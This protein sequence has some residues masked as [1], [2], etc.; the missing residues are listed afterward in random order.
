ML[1][2]LLADFRPT[3]ECPT[4]KDFYISRFSWISVTVIVICLF[5]TVFSAI[6]LGL[7]WKGPRYGRSITSQGSFKPSDAILLT[8]VMAK[9]IELSFVTSFVAFL[10]QV[11]SRRA[12]MREQGRGVTLSELSMWRW[13]VQPGT[14]ITHWETAKYAGISFLGI[15]SL[16]S[17]LLATLYT[18][19]ASAVVQP[20]LKSGEWEHTLLAGRVQ[21]DF[22]NVNYVSSICETPITTDPKNGAATCLQI[23][24]AGQGY[25]NYQRYLANWKETGVDYNNGTT[26]QTE[27]PPGFGLLHENTTITAQWINVINTTAVSKEHKRAINNVSLAMPHSGV[28]QAAR[29]QRNNILQ[30]EEL[31]SEGSYSIRASVPSPVMNVLCANM[32]ED[33]LA[34]IV[35]DTWNDVNINGTTWTTIS[36]TWENVTTT[37]DTVV[38]GKCRAPSSLVVTFH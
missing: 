29:D 24:H 19:A 18:V 33:E 30:P 8:Q 13:V 4:A 28:F 11:L 2:V 36:H 26:N 22:A 17:A 31:N 20:Q 37:N 12:F 34:P 32:A 21:T 1:T 7:A 16:L 10:G 23:E 38:D 6:F 9:L 15:L 35:F 14:L 5:S 3:Q 27:R 25:H